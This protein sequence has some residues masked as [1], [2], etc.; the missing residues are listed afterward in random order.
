MQGL[1]E[2]AYVNEF[3]LNPMHRIV[4]MYDCE[5]LGAIIQCVIY[6]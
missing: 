4:K 5:N 3:S 6:M 1:E 2:R